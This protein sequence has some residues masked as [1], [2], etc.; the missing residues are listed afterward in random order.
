MF[1]SGVGF[2]SGPI[3]SVGKPGGGGIMPGGPVREI[4]NTMT[5]RPLLLNQTGRMV[6]WW[7]DPVV[8]VAEYELGGPVAVPVLVLKVPDSVLV[9]GGTV[10]ELEM[11]KEESR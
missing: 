3:S 5:G 10:M 7:S 6:G 9:C 2:P 8:V 4:G 1:G 11:T